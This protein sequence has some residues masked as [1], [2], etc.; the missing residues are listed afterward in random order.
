MT[1]YYSDSL[2]TI[3]HGDCRELLPS[4]EADVIVT[5]PP[6]GEVSR[7]SQ[8]LRVFDKGSADME[9]LNPEEIVAALLP[10]GAH[11]YYVWCGME[12]ISPLRVGFVAAGLSTRLCVWEKSNPAPTNGQYLWLSGLE[13]AVFVRRHNAIFNEFCKVPIWRGPSAEDNGH[14]TPKPKWLMAR[15]IAASSAPGDTILD[16]FMGSGTTLFAAKDLGRRSIG[17][18]I[19]ERWCEQAAIRCS[20]G[21]LGLETA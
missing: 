15:A 3:W 13:V 16:P 21:V 8:G 2:V 17:I 18:E 14:P 10:V 20:Q 6:Y 4:I 19:E 11:S 5:D 1:P 9:T 12:Q 7:A